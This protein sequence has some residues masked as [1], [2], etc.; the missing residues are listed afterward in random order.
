VYSETFNQD[1]KRRFDT[2]DPTLLEI[3]TNGNGLYDRAMMKLGFRLPPD[4]RVADLRRAMGEWN[5]G[6][7]LELKYGEKA[8]CTGKNNPLVKALLPAIRAEGG[9]PRFVLKTGTSDMNVVGP[10]WGCPIVA[11]GPG[12]S[13]L[14]HTPNEHIVIDEYLRG[15]RVLTRA[16]QLLA[17]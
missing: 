10:V 15:V 9:R 16:L 17:N 3:R 13:S 1:K 8:H 5:D 4:F 6:A 14:D 7:E 11:Y 12:D 2:L